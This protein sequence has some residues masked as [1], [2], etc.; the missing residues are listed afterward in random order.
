M[1]MRSLRMLYA[2]VDLLNSTLSILGGHHKTVF[3]RAM[4]IYA[5][6]H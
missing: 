6:Y 3:C 2:G 5:V 4:L 1:V